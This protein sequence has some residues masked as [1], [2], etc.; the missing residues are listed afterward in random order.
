MKNILTLILLNLITI[1]LMAQTEKE[2]YGVGAAVAKRLKAQELNVESFQ[3][4]IDDVMNGKEL[5][6]S[7]AEIAGAYSMFLDKSKN[8]VHEENK[9]A[10]E[11]F[12]AANAK[13]EGVTT[14]D[15]GLQYEIIK[16]SNGP[17]PTISNKVTVHY[18]GTTIDGTVFDSSVE[19]GESI[20]F[21][22]SNVIKGW[23]EG[24]ALMPKGSKYRLFI[25]QELAY[26]SRGAG[27]IIKPFS[28]LIFEVEL[29]EI[30]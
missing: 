20:S 18:H 17:K 15:S 27:P 22:L 5:E 16:P 6:F 26:G 21:P 13:K 2:A 3:K 28:A 24:V 19:R 30:E 7:S 14:T 9:T 25:P 12:L 8:M 23:Q 1:G 11:D 10:G 29:L 4:G